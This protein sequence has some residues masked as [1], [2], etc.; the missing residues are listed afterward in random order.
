[1]QD[2]NEGEEEVDET[3]GTHH[4]MA[5]MKFTMLTAGI[6]GIGWFIAYF[7]DDL[8]MGTLFCLPCVSSALMI[9]VVLSFVGSTGSTTI[10]FILRT[11]IIFPP[12]S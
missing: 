2:G 8:Q 9:W 6:V 7:V 12:F 11:F 10:S 4:E 3:H 1:M 5:R